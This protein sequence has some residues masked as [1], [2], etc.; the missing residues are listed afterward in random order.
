MKKNLIRFAC[1][2]VSS[3]ILL[4]NSTTVYAY[5]NLDDDIFNKVDKYVIEEM[6][7]MRVP[8][9]S[10]GIVKGD[11]TFYLKGYG[12]SDSEGS[13]VTPDTPFILGS[14]TKTFTALAIR[15]LINERKIEENALVIKYLP[16][17]KTIDKNNS[18]NITINDLINHT[19]GFSTS[20]GNE[21]VIK[22][23]NYTLEQKIRKLARVKLEN[24]PNSVMQY[25]NINYGI[26]GLIIEK[27]SG[28]N[29]DK[30]IRNHIFGPLD[31]KDSF[32][33]GKETA[34]NKMAIGHKISFGFPISCKLKVP[35][36]G[37]P[38]G[39]LVSSSKDMCNYMIT[40]LHNGYF[41]GNSIIPNNEKPEDT[42]HSG[43][44][45]YNTYWRVQTTD[46]IG[47]SGAT[48]DF[49]TSMYANSSAKYGIIVLANCRNDLVT[50]VNH[51]SQGIF[52]ILN[53]YEATVISDKKFNKT[54]IIFD[55]ISIVLLILITIHL[56]QSIALLKRLYKGGKILARNVVS[57]ILIDFLIP[58]IIL[59]LG[60]ILSKYLY[61]QNLMWN[62]LIYCGGI[63]I[64]CLFI[65]SLILLT[66][67]IIKITCV[68]IIKKRKAN[69]AYR[70]KV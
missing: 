67:C 57:C 50:D 23:I 39:Y 11:K 22:N 21:Y 60:P 41:K 2:L 4:F 69:P 30:Y 68:S 64:A 25:S 14:I 17:F 42:Y 15:Q 48:P 46:I 3:I 51:I 37:V 55:T 61:N 31:M 63:E 66:T 7:A 8:G 24:L 56:V 52:S 44:M 65:I 32:V 40:Y 13:K 9:L 26:L 10:L 35:Y 6:K 54:Y 70:A 34:T 53:G 43:L 47:H 20:A 49:N 16:W 29:Y 1:I 58:I 5:S 27:V 38:V 33:M 18:D 59:A 28:E 45:D 36:A 12:T 19:S 62:N